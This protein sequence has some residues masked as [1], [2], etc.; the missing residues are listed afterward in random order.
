MQE[1]IIHDCIISA[2]DE[3]Q[4]NLNMQHGRSAFV[5]YIY[6]KMSYLTMLSATEIMDGWMD[7]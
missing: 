3:H 7:V 2:I 5:N 6:S 4:G 1:K